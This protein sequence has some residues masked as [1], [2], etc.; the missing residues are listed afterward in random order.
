[1]G[2]IDSASV[3]ETSEQMV[4]QTGRRNPFCQVPDWVLLA[5]D[6]S[7]QAKLLYW[8]MKAHVS[9]TRED[10]DVWPTQ[11]MLAEMLGFSEGRKLR[12]YI[13]ELL[14]IEAIKVRTIRHARSMRKRSIYTVYE[15]P[16]EGYGG[17]KELKE[18]YKKRKEQLLAAQ[19]E[20]AE[21]E[22][23]QAQLDLNIAS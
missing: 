10:N 23:A 6:L 18:F 5:P 16:P 4:M 7:R 8:A 17:I 11:D 14:A 21:Q 15:M 20:A 19:A 12:P 22:G 9:A 13:K 1:M 3:G 2:K